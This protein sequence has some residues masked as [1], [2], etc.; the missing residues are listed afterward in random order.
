MR[1]ARTRTWLG[2]GI[3][4]LLVALAALLYSTARP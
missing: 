1:G 4:V 2:F 3:I